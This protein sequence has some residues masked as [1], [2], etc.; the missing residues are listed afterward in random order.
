MITENMDFLQAGSPFPDWGFACE[1]D[2][3]ANA[4]HWPPFVEAF[5]EY[6]HE[7]YEPGTKE[8]D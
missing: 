2:N 6:I 5:V 4:G 7:T 3:A 8:Y 1:E